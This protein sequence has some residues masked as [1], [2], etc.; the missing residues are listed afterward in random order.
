MLWMGIL[1]SR[2]IQATGCL[3]SN[4]LPKQCSQAPIN[5]I[6]IEIYASAK[7]MPIVIMLILKNY[8]QQFPQ[9]ISIVKMFFTCPN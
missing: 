3:T 2:P 4:K 9:H 8:P 6:K 5:Y 7:F 1:F